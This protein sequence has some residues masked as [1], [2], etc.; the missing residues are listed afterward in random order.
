MCCMAMPVCNAGETQI[1][2]PD[3]CPQGA[4]CYSNQLCCSQI[5][6]VVAE[7]IACDAMPVCM[8]GETEV[9]PCPADASCVSRTLCGT[10][11][12]CQKPS[13]ECS[14]ASEYNREY[15]AESP[16]QCAT[17]RYA[18]DEGTTS[19]SNECGCGCEQPSACPEYVDCMPSID[20]TDPVHRLCSDSTECPL[21]PRYQ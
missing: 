19:F 8:A 2:G 11:I 20:P 13:S 17:L 6:C 12:V 18:C 16:E 5:W 3:A 21:T 10:S 1:S 9:S 15:V 4:T 7:S 14:P